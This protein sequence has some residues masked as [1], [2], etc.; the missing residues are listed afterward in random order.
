MCV[1]LSVIVVLLCFPLYLMVHCLEM[2]IFLRFI[3][4]TIFRNKFQVHAILFASVFKE[5]TL[6]KDYSNE[7]AY[8]CKRSFWIVIVKGFAC[9]CFFC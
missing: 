1:F 7:Y 6:F 2:Y 8:D 3:L 4:Q 5:G 9:H